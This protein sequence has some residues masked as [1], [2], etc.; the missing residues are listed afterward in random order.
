MN[1]LSFPTRVRLF[2]AG[3]PC[4]LF[5]VR[6]PPHNTQPSILTLYSTFPP[7]D[8]SLSLSPSPTPNHST[9]QSESESL[10]DDDELELLLLLLL[11]LDEEEE[12]ELLSL[13]LSLAACRRAAAC[14][15]A[16]YWT[17]G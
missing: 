8:P 7:F 6:Y 11:L 9:P 12:E 5:F 2:C 1:P 4:S 15:W 13:S 14:V 10:D 16:L 3:G 17:E